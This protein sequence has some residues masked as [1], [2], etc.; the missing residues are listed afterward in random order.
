M[1]EQIKSQEGAGLEE[2]LQNTR[3]CSL[4]GKLLAEVNPGPECFACRVP[5]VID[6]DSQGRVFKG[7]TTFKVI[8]P[9]SLCTSRETPGFNRAYIE[10]HGWGRDL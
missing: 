1:K 2:E 9:V 7:P 4:C 10:Y 8:S 3:R 5:K 6:I